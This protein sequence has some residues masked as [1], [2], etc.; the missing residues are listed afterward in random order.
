LRSA[1]RLA[2]VLRSRLAAALLRRE[3]RLGLA[4]RRRG[5]RRA[6]RVVRAGVVGERLGRVGLDGLWRVGLRLG[7]RLRR[8]LGRVSRLVLLLV[9]HVFRFFLQ[10]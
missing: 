1:T 9:S 6:Q 4:R 10:L 8:L 3:L 7:S 2:G 5:D